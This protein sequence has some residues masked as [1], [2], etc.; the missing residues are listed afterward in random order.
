MTR[1]IPSFNDGTLK[2]I[3]NPILHFDNFRYVNN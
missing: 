1:F 3:K 2:F